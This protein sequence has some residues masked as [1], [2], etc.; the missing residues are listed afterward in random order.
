MVR[1]GLIIVVSAYLLGVLAL[2]IG[3]GASYWEAGWSLDKALARAIARALLWP[4]WLYRD[5]T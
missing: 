5:L 2:S 3:L 1:I 4:V